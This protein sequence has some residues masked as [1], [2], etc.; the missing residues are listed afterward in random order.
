ME[1]PITVISQNVMADMYTLNH[2]NDRYGHVKDKSVL[3]WNYRY[4]LLLKRIINHEIICLQEVEL[5]NIPTSKIFMKE[6]KKINKDALSVSILS[7]DSVS[8]LGSYLTQK[9]S[10]KSSQAK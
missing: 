2:A 6:L 10:S 1:T 7:D 5:K 3:E 4:P 8:T 9:F